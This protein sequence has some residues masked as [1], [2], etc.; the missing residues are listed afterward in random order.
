MQTIQYK[1]ITGSVK[2]RR[3]LMSQKEENAERKKIDQQI[4]T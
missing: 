3:K 4:E 1:N 2:P